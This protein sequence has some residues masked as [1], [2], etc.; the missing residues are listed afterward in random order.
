MA[1]TGSREP[2]RGAVLGNHAARKVAHRPTVG[3]TPTV[4]TDARKGGDLSLFGV[5]VRRNN[6]NSQNEPGM[7]FGINE[8]CRARS[9]PDMAATGSREPDRGRRFEVTVGP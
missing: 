6:Q 9:G 2:D 4:A 8:P 1:A 3:K 5:P 7:S